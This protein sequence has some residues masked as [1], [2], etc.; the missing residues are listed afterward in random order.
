V[1][2]LR[3][4]ITETISGYGAFSNVISTGERYEIKPLRAF[5][6]TTSSERSRILVGVAISKQTRTA[7]ERNRLKRLLRE[8]LHK[9]EGVLNRCKRSHRTL[10]IIV[11]YIGSREI[12]PKRVRFF[13]IEQSMNQLLGTI[14]ENS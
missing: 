11:M 14:L 12:A 3:R 5:V 10:E 6:K 4:S 2:R 8:A 13:S 1:P 7:V 9:K